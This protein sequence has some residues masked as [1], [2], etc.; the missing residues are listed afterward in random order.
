MERVSR[1]LS[2]SILLVSVPASCLS[3]QSFGRVDIRALQKGNVVTFKTADTNVLI[4][5]AAFRTD[6]PRSMIVAQK[7]VGTNW[8]SVTFQFTVP[9]D[10]SMTLILRG[11]YRES[12]DT[13]NAAPEWVW[14]DNV[15][16]TN[17]AGDELCR[18]GSFEKVHGFLGI[19]KRDGQPEKWGY[20]GE[21]RQ[22]RLDETKAFPQ[23]GER[24]VR[25]KHDVN[26]YQ[27]LRVKSNVWYTVTAYFRAD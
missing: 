17:A 19:L 27:P 25:L 14:A 21:G 5:Y 20:R 3:Q 2:A 8:T 12:T 10:D 16:V 6:G 7:P 11:R 24:C 1:F 15:S 23:D 13:T 18:N 22:I 4:G 26:A 9:R